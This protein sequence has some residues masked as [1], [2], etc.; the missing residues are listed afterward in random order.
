MNQN[1]NAHPSPQGKA[2][3]I[4]EELRAIAE[5]RTVC[6]EVYPEYVVGKDR[7]VAVGYNLELYGTH[8]HGHSHL[9]PGCI[10]CRNTFEDLQRIAEWITPKEQRDSQYRI[11]PYEP[12]LHGSAK[13][14]FR[15]E[16]RLALQIQHRQNFAEPIDDCERRC[17]QE[18]Q[19]NLATLGIR[20]G[21][22]L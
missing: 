18:M 16:V 4:V 15:P 5:R 10:H 13:R 22:K 9:T 1:I 6:Y 12:S 19:D 3:N 14:R 21:D 11:V 8:D 17:L 2:D 20:F 7:P